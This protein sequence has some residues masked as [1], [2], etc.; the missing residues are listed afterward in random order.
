MAR[1]PTTG[2]SGIYSYGANLYTDNT[3]YPLNERLPDSMVYTFATGRWAV[4]KEKHYWTFSPLSSDFSLNSTYKAE[5]AVERYTQEDKQVTIP[6]YLDDDTKYMRTPSGGFMFRQTTPSNNKS[7]GKLA[8]TVNDTYLGWLNWAYNQTAKY[9]DSFLE[10]EHALTNWDYNQI[11]IYPLIRGVYGSKYDT[12]NQVI[13]KS[14]TGSPGTNDPVYSPPWVHRTNGNTP[15]R[16]DLKTFYEDNVKPTHTDDFLGYTI[17]FEIYQ[18][19]NNSSQ[20]PTKR[21]QLMQE[22]H[23]NGKYTEQEVDVNNYQPFTITYNDEYGFTPKTCLLGGSYTTIG[24]VESVFWTGAKTI[25][26]IEIAKLVPCLCTTYYGNYHCGHIPVI[27]PD[28]LDDPDHPLIIAQD[29]IQIA[30]SLGLPVITDQAALRQFN[31]SNMDIADIAE[32]YENY[33]FYPKKKGA[34]VS[35]EENVTGA[36]NIRNTP[37]YEE[38]EDPMGTTPEIDRDNT[39]T[40]DYV[41]EVGLT[42]PPITPVGVFSRYYAL[43]KNDLDDFSEFIYDSDPQTIQLVLDGLKLNGENPMNFMIGLRMFPFKLLDFID[44]ETEEIGFGNGVATGVTAEKI[45]TDSFIIELGECGF[46]TYFGNFLDYEPYTT[47]KLYIPYCNE[48]E[49]PTAVFAG[50]RIKVHLIV[51]ITTG[52]CI[53]CISKVTNGK[54]EVVMYTT[55]M[56]GVEIPM[57]G[58]NGTEYVKG[59]IEAASQVASGALSVASSAAMM[60]TTTFSDVTSMGIGGNVGEISRAAVTQGTSSYDMLSHSTSTGATTRRFN[61]GGILGGVADIAKGIYDFNTMPTP[62]Q[63]QGQGSPYTNLYKPQHCYFII[64]RPVPMNIE[65]VM[66]TMGYACLERNPIS[67]YPDGTFLMAQNPNVQPEHATSNETTELNILLSTGVWK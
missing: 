46:P 60:G 6:A 35:S 27:D 67:A 7:V 42:H 33:V 65:G 45:G 59:A 32:D 4:D 3:D 54:A 44:S 15:V 8:V 13:V 51:D 25:E 30:L 53:G 37:Q 12:D 26:G 1:I 39:D 56:I 64:Q 63:I 11:A 29:I 23:L 2:T 24:K 47:A 50:H 58:T 21:F 31:M 61:T 19:G 5:H 18:K 17:E 22:H 66:N 9:P 34:R 49:I 57:I 28:L 41:D 48:V 36:D 62:L 16:Y 10:H 14:R 52:G 43:S 55:G 20:S 40:N 38:H